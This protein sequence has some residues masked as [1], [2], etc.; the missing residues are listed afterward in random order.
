[1]RLELGYTRE[2]RHIAL[3]RLSAEGAREP[4]PWSLTLPGAKLALE[5]RSAQDVIARFARLNATKL[6]ALAGTRLVP[7]AFGEKA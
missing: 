1:M 6:N 3:Y 4:G 2:G 7:L 5:A